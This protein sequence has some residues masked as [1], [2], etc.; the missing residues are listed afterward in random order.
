LVLKVP[1]AVS[2]NQAQFGI[3]HKEFSLGAIVSEN[4][5]DLQDQKDPSNQLHMLSRRRRRKVKSKAILNAENEENLSEK[6]PTEGVVL[7]YRKSV[8]DTVNLVTLLALTGYK[9]A[10]MVKNLLENYEKL[11]EYIP[12][13]TNSPSIILFE[14][15]IPKSV[16]AEDRPN[17]KELKEAP[18]EDTNKMDSQK[19]RNRRQTRRTANRTISSTKMN[20]N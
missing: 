13:K 5:P 15:N 1:A 2:I 16:V 9:V 8:S 6:D 4:D 7:E 11:T 3:P 10:A 20:Q 18:N 19:S 17:S 12:K 14:E